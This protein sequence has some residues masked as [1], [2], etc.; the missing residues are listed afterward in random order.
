MIDRNAVGRPGKPRS[1]EVE[2]G[3]LRFFAKAI[4]ETNP[5]Y[6]A[7]DAARAAGFRSLPVP[8]TF[9]FCLEMDRPEPFEDLLELGIDLGAILH[10]E[11]SFVYHAPI[12]AGDRITIE[13]RITDI[14]EKKG[15]ALEFLV[16]DY[17]FKNQEDDLVAEMRRV[18]VVRNQAAGGANAV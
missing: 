18:I 5:I 2:K 4:G 15:G 13:S 6:F 9:P 16:Q 12:C 14:Y 7:E 1:V 11:Q 10:G 8:P 17:V 3:R